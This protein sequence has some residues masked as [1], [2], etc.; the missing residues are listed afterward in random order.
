MQEFAAYDELS[1]CAIDSFAADE[2]WGKE[3]KV[4]YTIE[5][6]FDPPIYFH[7]KLTNF[8]QN[9]RSYVKSRSEDQLQNVM[10]DNGDCDP[11][12]VKTATGGPDKGNIMLPCGLI[13]NSFFNDKYKVRLFTPD[14]NGVFQGLIFVMIQLHVMAMRKMELGVIIHGMHHQIGRIV[15]LHGNQ[16]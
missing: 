10:L 5:Y 7:Y 4:N 8:Y 15:I 6:D 12:E 16:I 1:D 2:N 14:V 13:A 11:S 9:H 3:C